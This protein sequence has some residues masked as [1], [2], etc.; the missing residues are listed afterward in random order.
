[1]KI[2]YGKT[3]QNCEEITIS[4]EGM[5]EGELYYKIADILKTDFDA[6]FDLPLDGFDTIYWDFW[7]DGHRVT[8]HYQVFFGVV[9][10]AN[11]KKG[12]EAIWKIGEYLSQLRLSP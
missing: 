4:E 3:R 9:I 1:M 10:F 6:T 7:V 2:T 8:L 12:G 5:D 11:D